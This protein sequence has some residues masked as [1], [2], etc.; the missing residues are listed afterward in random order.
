[1]HLL[2][3]EV[4]KPTDPHPILE[5]LSPVGH[6]RL[7]HID[8]PAIVTQPLHAGPHRVLHE[9]P[10]MHRRVHY[11]LSAIIRSSGTLVTTETSTDAAPS[12]LLGTQVEGL[13]LGD[14]G[15]RG[16]RGYGFLA[17]AESRV[18]LRVLLGLLLAGDILAGLGTMVGGMHCFGLKGGLS[19]LLV[20]GFGRGEAVQLRG[21]AST[22]IPNLLNGNQVFLTSLLPLLHRALNLAPLPRRYRP[23]LLLILRVHIEI[24]PRHHLLL[25]SRRIR[26][27]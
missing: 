8:I 1:M 12:F 23:L 6:S 27:R 21:S 20:L 14:E 5:L 16:G 10:A 25:L 19:Q 26:H 22:R 2:S 17:S 9:L 4:F 3:L 24:L 15:V 11:R 7:S 13:L 18:C